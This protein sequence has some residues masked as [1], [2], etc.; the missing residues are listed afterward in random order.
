MNG[1]TEVFTSISRST[2]MSTE[3]GLWRVQR[4]VFEPRLSPCRSACP[5]GN[6]IAESLKL[7]KDGEFQKAWEVFLETSP[8][9]FTCGDVCPHPCESSCNRGKFDEAISIRS[10]ER[11]LGEEAIKNNWFPQRIAEDKDE[12]VAIIGSGPAGLSCAYQLGRRGYQVTIF[13]ALPVIGGML[14][15]GIQDY[16]LPRDF[17]GREIGNNILLPFAV[18]VRTNYLV[19]QE[20]FEKIKQE[21]QAVFIATGAQEARALNMAGVNLGGVFHGVS[22]LRDKALGKLPPDLFA[23]Q[24]V[25]VIG[26]G[27]VAVDAGRSALR[28][29]AKEVRLVCLESQ[30]E[31]PAYEQDIKDAVNEGI[32]IDCSW[33][34][35]EF[36]GDGRGRV[37]E[38]HFARCTS[39]FDAK[40]RF[41]PSFD[42]SVKKSYQV[43]AVIIAIGQA[44]DLSF[45]DGRVK[46]TPEERVKVNDALA[47]DVPGVFAGGDVVTQPATVIEAVAAGYKAALSIDNYLGGKPLTLKE[48]LGQVVEFEEL[49][50]GYFEHKTR[51]S[52]INDPTSAIEEAK[53]CFSCGY[54]NLCGNCWLFCP[55]AAV[56]RG[57]E[58]YEFNYDYC[59]GCGICV[60]EC[61]TKSI[62]LKKERDVKESITDR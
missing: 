28:L 7:V 61:P 52:Q 1:S 21:F 2:T 56:R 43:D 11:F 29:G 53:R 55:D 54:C 19:T 40:G 14:Q 6:H 58:H 4:P 44:S 36:I 9:P 16:R 26:G 31:I 59:K 22:F 33:G 25:L 30:E 3:T 20:V 32:G 38:V 45:L 24:K 23:G 17:L 42:R 8:F 12:K 60:E 46:R 35:E 47:T 18:N 51:Q 10:V 62:I 37:N 50:L 48:E 5:A 39:V 34:P 49:N 57:N 15:V 13:E 41:S 27:G